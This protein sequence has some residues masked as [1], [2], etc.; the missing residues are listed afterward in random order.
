MQKCIIAHIKIF[1]GSETVHKILRMSL[2]V[3]LTD[4]GGKKSTQALESNRNPGHYLYLYDQDT[5]FLKA[6]S[7]VSFDHH[8]NFLFTITICFSPL[9]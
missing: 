1:L 6:V 2:T 5:N 8:F 3:T 9:P 4:K 7:H